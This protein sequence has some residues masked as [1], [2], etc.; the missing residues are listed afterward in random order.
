MHKVKKSFV[1][2]PQ[3]ELFTEKKTSHIAGH[4]YVVLG[5]LTDLRLLAGQ[6]NNIFFFLADRAFPTFFSE[7]QIAGN[8]RIRASPFKVI[9]DL[10]YFFVTRHWTTS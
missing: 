2:Y 8:P 4:I 6:L 3:T 1:S 5:R 9:L 10:E 7:K